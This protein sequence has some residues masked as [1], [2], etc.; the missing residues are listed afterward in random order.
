MDLQILLEEQFNRELIDS[1]TAEFYLE[2]GRLMVKHNAKIYTFYDFLKKAKVENDINVLLS[3]LKKKMKKTTNYQDLNKYIRDAFFKKK[4]KMDVIGR[5]GTKGFSIFDIP[6]IEEYNEFLHNAYKK[7][8]VE[9]YNFLSEGVIYHGNK[10]ADEPYDESEGVQYLRNKE[11]GITIYVSPVVNIEKTDDNKNNLKNLV[12]SIKT[13]LNFLKNKKDSYIEDM[14]AKD[15]MRKEDI[16][17]IRKV[18]LNHGV[19]D[20]SLSDVLGVYKS[21]KEQSFMIRVLYIPENK[22]QPL[23]RDLGRAF[24]QESVLIEE[25]ASGDIYFVYTTKDEKRAIP[26][27]QNKEGKIYRREKI[28]TQNFKLHKGDWELTVKEIDDE[29]SRLKA[30]IN[31]QNTANDTIY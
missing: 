1:V 3:F 29:I 11:K 23:A 16:E 31:Q 5:K 2:N 30:E 6:D 9:S 12:N 19:E 13:K 10:T 15:K 14:K 28:D 22:I 17:K 7:K 4:E 27:F 8:V 21:L 18:F 25:H 24:E 20:F 26:H